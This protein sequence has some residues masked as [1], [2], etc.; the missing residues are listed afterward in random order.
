MRSNESL[1]TATAR[2]ESW[3]FLGAD[4]LARD[5]IHL[6]PRSWL[7]LIIEVAPVGVTDGIF[8]R[9]VELSR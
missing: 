1:K 8:R 2:F 3:S 9:D 6:R 5:Q 4:E 7:D